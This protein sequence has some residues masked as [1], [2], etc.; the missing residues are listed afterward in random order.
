MSRTQGHGLV[1]A[2]TPF[3]AMGWAAQAPPSQVPPGPQCLCLWVREHGEVCF[4]LWVRLLRKA[5]TQNP[6]RSRPFFFG[7]AAL[8]P[9]PCL[10]L[11]LLSQKSDFVCLQTR[12]CLTVCTTK[13]YVSVDCCVLP[14]IFFQSLQNFCC[15][16]RKNESVF[17]MRPEHLRLKI[18]K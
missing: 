8:D 11:R 2:T 1:A 12:P 16:L 17:I 9:D 14:L 13:F 10:A 3:P 18:C 7:R 4:C 5:R 15:A 6:E